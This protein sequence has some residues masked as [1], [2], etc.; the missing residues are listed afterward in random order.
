MK[1]LTK[2]LKIERIRKRNFEKN[3]KEKLRN[4]I[5]CSEEEIIEIDFSAFLSFTFPFPE[6]SFYLQSLP[7]RF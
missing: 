5:L 6:L 4:Q 1:K 2:N 3:E 7:S